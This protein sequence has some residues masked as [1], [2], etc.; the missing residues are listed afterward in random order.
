[1]QESVIELDQDFPLFGYKKGDRISVDHSINPVHG[2]VVITKVAEHYK[3]NRFERIHE[4]ESLWPP[5]QH[6]P[7]D[8]I[9]FGVAI[10]LERA[11]D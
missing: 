9:L 1:M 6:S 10:K 7:I 11:I 3:V 4:V 2:S 5:A 8:E